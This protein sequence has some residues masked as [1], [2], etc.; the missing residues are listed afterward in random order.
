[1][2]IELSKSK[3]ETDAH[4]V[5]RVMVSLRDFA[6]YMPSCDAFKIVKLGKILEYHCSDQCVIK[7]NS[8]ITG[9]YTCPYKAIESI[10]YVTLLHLNEG[11]MF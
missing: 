9:E 4:Y 3:D 6:K 10:A 5:K 11:G 1:M 7:N 2:N 8:K